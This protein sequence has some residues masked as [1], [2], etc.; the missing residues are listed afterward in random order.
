[1]VAV[2]DPGS[3]QARLSDNSS[4]G[5]GMGNPPRAGAHAA[6]A[7]VGPAVPMAGGADNGEKIEPGLPDAVSDLLHCRA[8][9]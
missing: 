8:L 2:D 9:K 3:V 6:S 7:V 1:M 5:G 4:V